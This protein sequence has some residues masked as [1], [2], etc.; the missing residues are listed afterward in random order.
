MSKTKL[1]IGIQDFET[2][3]TDGYVY[4]DKT[5]LIYQLITRGKPNFLSRPR[6]FGKSLL[7]SLLEALFSGKRHLFKGL[8]IDDSS[9]EWIEYPVIRLD[10]SSINNEASETFKLDLIRV[11]KNIALENNLALEGV[12]PAKY[13][14]DL[15]RKLSVK[16]KVVVLI[17]E[18]DKPLI[19]NIDNLELAKENRKVL[20]QFYTI[21]KSEDR[22]LKFIFLTGVTKFSKVSVFSGLNNLNDLTMSNEYS[23]LLGYTRD[24]EN[25]IFQKTFERLLMQMGSQLKAVMIELKNG[26]MA[27]NFQETANGSTILFQP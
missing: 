11:L 2:I 23:A 22:H 19:D 26:I 1:P 12:S 27:I 15:I 8:W 13:L 5:E 21:L 25:I 4:V 7:I 16:Q 10:M 17:D 6:R 14:E 9:W 24:E 18:F 20:Q 3:I